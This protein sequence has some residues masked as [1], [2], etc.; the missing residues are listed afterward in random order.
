[1]YGYTKKPYRPRHHIT[2]LELDCEHIHWR[3]EFGFRVKWLQVTL[4]TQTSHS[5]CQY[6]LLTCCTCS[7]QGYGRSQW[8]VTNRGTRHHGLLFLNHTAVG[9]RNKPI[10]YRY[11]DK[12][13]EGWLLLHDITVQEMCLFLAINCRWGSV[14]LTHRKI[15]GWHCNRTLH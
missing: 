7:P 8:I 4:L 10:C 3:T 6:K 14:R 15:T 13:D 11:C 9:C 5:D 2:D 1:M 12:L